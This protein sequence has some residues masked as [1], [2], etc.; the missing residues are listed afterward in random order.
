MRDLGT[1]LRATPQDERLSL[2]RIRWRL[3]AGCSLA[4]FGVGQAKADLI[5]QLY[6]TSDAIELGCHMARIG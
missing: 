4:A 1:H 6:R 3:V 5:P 2:A